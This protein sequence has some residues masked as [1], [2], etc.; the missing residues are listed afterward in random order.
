MRI[1][2]YKEIED[3]GKICLILLFV[4]AV[5]LLL[6]IYNG[7]TNK[8][9]ATIKSFLEKA[10]LPVGHTMYIWGGGWNEED[11]EAGGTATQIGL[12]PRWKEFYLQ[13]DS[14]YDFEMHRFERENGLDC[15]G[16]VGWAIYNTFETKDGK[17]GYVTSST[18]MAEEFAQLGWGDIVKD[19]T[20]FLPGDIVSME[21]H[22]WIC[23]GTCQDG[24]VLLVHSSPPGVSV[25]GTQMSGTDSIAVQIATEYMSKY[26]P[27]WQQQYPNR[28][29]PASYLENVTVFRWN[30]RVMLDAKRLQTMSA[31]E[32]IR[33]EK[34]NQKN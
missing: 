34:A 23:L 7:R 22:V 29:V 21:G 16:Y 28:S 9:E 12:S 33:M 4:L 14:D 13:Q 6:A 10:L 5:L 27:K 1:R 32:V 20:Q 30:E 24:S 31:E 17:D 15:S 26:Y 18:D 19:S 8:K 2:K 25:C 11:S 3:M